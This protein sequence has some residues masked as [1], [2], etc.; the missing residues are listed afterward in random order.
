MISFIDRAA[1]RQWQAYLARM[2]ATL[3]QLDR[4]T[5]SDLRQELVAHL[6]DAYAA[7][8]GTEVERVAMATAR[9]GAPEA[10]LRPLLADRLIE[11]GTRGFA[12]LTLT[13]GLAHEI[14]RGGRAAV[15]GL[16]FLIGYTALA[17]FAAMA[18]LQPVLPRHVGLFAFPDGRIQ[19]GIVR[20]ADGATELLGWWT[21]P[22]ALAATAGLWWVLGRVLRRVRAV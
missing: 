6:G 11:R 16:V 15:M 22:I 10:F 9:L 4:T 20:D 18:V 7:A 12:P 2:D 14:A 19:F 17:A 1:E 5:A 3:S 21:I 8:T 13:R